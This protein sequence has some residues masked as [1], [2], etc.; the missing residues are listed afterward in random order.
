M[1][2]PGRCGT[3]ASVLPADT[4]SCRSRILCDCYPIQGHPVP[5]G[6]RS[7]C[8][9]GMVLPRDVKNYLSVE[10]LHMPRDTSCIFLSA[11]ACIGRVYLHLEEQAMSL[12]D[13]MCLRF[14]LY[15]LA[16]YILAAL[17]SAVLSHL[18]CKV[19]LVKAC[20][21]HSMWQF[22]YRVQEVHIIQS[23]ARACTM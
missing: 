20:M 12:M 6:L 8:S 18:A 2:F 13:M 14:H 4:A 5:C 9:P 21:M 3:T 23:P 17:S 19:F 22:N 1:T 7:R 10:H 16:A 11:S 15:S